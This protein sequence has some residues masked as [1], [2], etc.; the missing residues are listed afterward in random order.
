MPMGDAHAIGAVELFVRI[1]LTL[2]KKEKVK[3]T[4]ISLTINTKIASDKLK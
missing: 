4:K 1:D 2:A 3:W